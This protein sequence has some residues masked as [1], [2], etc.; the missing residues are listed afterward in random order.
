MLAQ[1]DDENEDEDDGAEDEEDVAEDDD[2]GGEEET[3]DGVDPN[4]NA[5]DLKKDKD[6]TTVTE[7]KK[8]AAPVDLKKLADPKKDEI[9]KEDTKTETK[10]PADKKN[11]QTGDVKYEE[12]PAAHADASYGDGYTRVVPPQYTEMRDDRL[13]N[14]L[15]SKYAREVKKDGKLTGQMFLNK[16]DAQ[17]V[18]NE[19]LKDHVKHTATESA[20]FEG[21]WKHFDV[22]NDGLVEVE[23]MP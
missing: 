23:R 7:D 14:S 17:N 12:I 21:T 20:D 3:A 6:T 22:N 15:I 9:K 18:T 16:E 10:P 4:P 11:V 13:M 8:E 2:D 19:V 1:P 5:P